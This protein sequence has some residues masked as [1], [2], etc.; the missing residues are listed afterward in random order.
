MPA[1]TAVPLSAVQ[2]A[3]VILEAIMVYVDPLIP[4]TR[5][6]KFAAGSCHLTADT[7][8]ELH[9]FAARLGLKRSWFQNDPR[10]PHYDLVASKRVQAV[11]L[12]AVEI[13]MVEA[14]RRI[15]A[16]RQQAQ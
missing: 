11:K 15:T 9:T 5:R 13:S 3:L 16:R 1:A 8:A 6:G 7:L 4:Y 14:G 2:E 10:M 12:G